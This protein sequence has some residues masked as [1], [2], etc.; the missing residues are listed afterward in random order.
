[1]YILII[2]YCLHFVYKVSFFRY[3][4]FMYI[5]CYLYYYF[6]KTITFFVI[7]YLKNMRTALSLKCYIFLLFCFVENI[8]LYL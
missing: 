3:L 2:T 1:M 6:A 7:C 4:L 5:F 8:F